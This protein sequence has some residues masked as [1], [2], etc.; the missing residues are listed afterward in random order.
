MTYEETE[1]F[2][3]RERQERAAAKSTAN[4]AA[5]RAHQ[6]L[7]EYYAAMLHKL[8]AIDAKILI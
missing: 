5:R 2:R 7:A 8:A 1:Y 3:R 6:Q 4:L